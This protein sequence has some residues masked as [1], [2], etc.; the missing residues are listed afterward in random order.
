[1]RKPISGGGLHAIKYTIGKACDVGPIR[2]WRAMRSKNACKTCALGMGGQLG[3]MVNE[4]RSFPEVCKKSLQAMASDMQGRIEPRFFKTYSLDELKGMS[5]RELENCGRLA[6]PLLAGPGDT[7]YRVVPW[8]IALDHL[9]LALKATEPERTFLYASGRSSNE[10]GFI[11]Q[12]LGRAH[13]TNHVTNC[14]YYC[15][16]ASGVGLKDSLGGSTSTCSLEDLDKCDMIFVVGGNPASNH[17][18]LMTK[19]MEV[20]R[21]GGTVVVVNPLREVGLERFRVPSKL[22]SLVF[23]SDIASTYVQPVIGG[24]IAFM[25]GLAKAVVERNGVDHEFIHAYTENFDVVR[26]YLTVTTWI[27]IEQRSGVSRRVIEDV[28]TQYIR[29][30]RAIF[31]WTMG[32]THHEHGVQNVHWIVNLALLRGMV[33]KP[34]AGA[35]PIR[36]HSNVQGVGSMGV[37]PEIRDDVLKKLESM[38]ICAPP[39]KGYDTLKTLE[40]AARS[41]MDFGM[42]L[43]GNLFG[44]SPDSDYTGEAL[45]KVKTLA[46]L[47]TT[48]NTG[49]ARG[50]GLTTLVLPCLARDEDPQSTT[51]ESMFN[52][53]RLSDGGARRL[54]GPRSEVEILTEI[55]HRALGSQGPIDW[56]E[57]TSHD[58]IRNLI[59]ELLPDLKLIKTIGATKT[60]FEIPGRVLHEPKFKTPSGKAILKCD[61]IPAPVSLGADQLRLTTIRSEGQFNTVVYEEEDFYRGQDRRDVILMNQLDMDR[62]GLRAGQRINV[63]SQTGVMIGILVRTYD[64]AAGCAAMYYPEANVLIPR[65]VDPASKTPAFKSVA[66]TIE[67]INS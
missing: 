32:L 48:L 51:Q 12:L 53:V 28:A 39:F 13:G 21:R 34:G 63:R 36:G 26:E 61:P 37:T 55:A 25:V 67:K 19:L 52:Y 14:S 30:Q 17:P 45:S 38:G 62:F 23:G 43:G 66:I 33:G 16:N 27:E 35:L 46:Y 42:C 57:L 11:L 31:S 1:M 8:D 60:E 4:Q 22:R 18:R 50:R 24:D 7:H 47:S 15:H 10:A 5:S 6:D 41:E 58:E 49:H 54:D 44:A 64:I 20:R 56:Q 29:S 2:L 3:G 65:T 59:S 40:A 9:A